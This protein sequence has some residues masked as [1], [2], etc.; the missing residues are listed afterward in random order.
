MRMRAL[1]GV[2]GLVGPLL[3]MSW[4][5]AAGA[6]TPPPPITVSRT[7]LAWEDC[8]DTPAPTDFAPPN[9]EIPYAPALQC[10]TVTV[11]LDYDEPEGR[12]VPLALYRVVSPNQNGPGFRG[13]LVLNPGGP[14]GE[15]ADFVDY[16][17]AVAPLPLIAAYDLVSFDPRGVGAS[18]GLQCGLGVTFP[19]SVGDDPVAEQLAAGAQLAAECLTE[20]AAMVANMGTTNVA[21]DLD[22][23]RAA[24]GMD[25]LDYL[26]YSYGT[27]IG[28]VY[29]EMFPD[30]VGRFVLDGALDPNLSYRSSII[31]QMASFDEVLDR[32]FTICDREP[33]CA[34]NPGGSEAN[35]KALLDAATGEGLAVG[36]AGSARLDG[37][38][39]VSAVLGYLYGGNATFP[40]LADALAQAVGGD[41]TTLAMDAE[42]TATQS[43]GTYFAVTCADSDAVYDR[44]DANFA[45]WA[46]R[47]RATV[48]TPS[49]LEIL[50]CAAFPPAKQ[51]VPG[52]NRNDLPPALIIGNTHDPATPYSGAVALHQAWGGSALLTYEGDGHTVALN[53][54]RCVDDAV[55]RYFVLGSLPGEGA[56]CRPNLSV[57]LQLTATA[58]GIVVI[59]VDPLGA[60]AD[61]VRFGDVLIAVDGG[62]ISPALLADA[63][64]GGQP[65][66]LTVRRD[67]EVLDVKLSGAY[68]AYWMA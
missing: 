53:G 48:F 51:P 65:F 20:D 30:R 60:A 33:T 40:Y 12:S 23:I 8:E 3:S 42:A 7:T 41:A 14:G 39:F 64:S 52:L 1:L 36:P 38:D 26:G 10:A 56:R 4:V 6:E 50:T 29:A 19:Y 17:A 55:V 37:P 21:R 67:G 58:Q 28:A 5:A 54:Q 2:A 18:D 13:S 11:P 22:T 31:D 49:V 57:G 43:I 34:F 62:A 16:S 25:K 35:F 24:L 45:T 59:Q 32:F 61:V 47:D 44:Y 68:P 27:R 63:V 15:G 46:L 66:V 9:V